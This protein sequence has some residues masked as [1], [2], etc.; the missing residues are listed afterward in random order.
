MYVPISEQVQIPG[1]QLEAKRQTKGGLRDKLFWN[2]RLTIAFCG[3]Y[4]LLYPNLDGLRQTIW[5]PSMVYTCAYNM[6]C[7]HEL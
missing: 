5:S 1:E 3:G 6:R 2:Y 7:P 4:M